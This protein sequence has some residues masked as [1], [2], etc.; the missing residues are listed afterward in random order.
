MGFLEWVSPH[1][2]CYLPFNKIN[3][4]KSAIKPLIMFLFM[5]GVS[6]TGIEL[7][8]TAGRN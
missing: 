4:R 7:V 5:V 2:M 6:I 3:S 8:Q 1:L